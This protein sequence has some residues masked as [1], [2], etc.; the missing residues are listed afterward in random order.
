MPPKQDL[1]KE[2]L[3]LQ[4]KQV[5]LQIKNSEILKSAVEEGL[6]LAK[7]YFE[8]KMH[9]IEGPKIRWSIIGFL[10]ILIIIVLGT[11]FLVYE[12]KLDSG[13]FTFLLGTLI[14]GAITFLGDLLLTHE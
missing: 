11:G 12:G 2:M 10:G 1:Q 9:H 14:G 6:P 5:D 3:K 7:E 13:S 4:Q 8:K